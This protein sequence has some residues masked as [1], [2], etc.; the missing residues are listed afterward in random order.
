MTKLLAKILVL[1]ALVAFLPSPA[2][3]DQLS[4]DL[5]AL[6]SSDRATVEHAVNSILG[7]RDAEA[8]VILVALLDDKL[9]V[10]AAGNAYRVEE[11][12]S[13]KPLTKAPGQGGRCQD[14]AG[15]Q[16]TAARA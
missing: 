11:D 7:K 5:R 1:C 16:S 12:G 13:L 14:A 2:K 3:A 10:D 8:L 15:Q 9:Q 6:N 4:E